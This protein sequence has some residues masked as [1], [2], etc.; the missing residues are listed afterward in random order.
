MELSPSWEATSRLATQEF[1]KTL[2]NQVYCR[3]D[4]SPQ[5][6]PIRRYI[7]P[8]IISLKSILILSFHL[9]P[10]PSSDLFP[11]DFPTKIVHEFLF[12]QIHTLQLRCWNF[13]HN[14]RKT[15]V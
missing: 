5:L 6:V 11:S 2:Q 7:P 4:R 9:C 1:P 8:H 3:V 15:S 10:A 12:K 13:H 14:F